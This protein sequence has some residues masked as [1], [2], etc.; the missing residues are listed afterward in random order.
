MSDGQSPAKEVTG[1]GGT[2]GNSGKKT[3]KMSDGQSPAKEVTGGGGTAG[4]SGKK[5]HKMSDGQSPAKE[6]TGG[7]GTAGNSGN[8]AAAKDVTQPPS[9][10]K[11]GRVAPVPLDKPI[12][13]IKLRVEP[14][15]EG[16]KG[17]KERHVVIVQR[18]SRTGEQHG[19]IRFT[20]IETHSPDADVPTE[21]W[22]GHYTKNGVQHK[23]HAAPSSH[24][25]TP[26]NHAK[27]LEVLDFVYNEFSPSGAKFYVRIV[28]DSTVQVVELLNDISELSSER[29]CQNFLEKNGNLVQVRWALTWQ[30]YREC[31]KKTMGQQQ[32]LPFKP[33]ARPAEPTFSA[34]NLK[35]FRK[36]IETVYFS[37]DPYDRLE[38]QVKLIAA[39]QMIELALDQAV[40]EI[41]HFIPKELHFDEAMKPD[42]LTAI[43]L[44]LA[45]IPE[46]C[47]SDSAED[48]TLRAI[49]RQLF[50]GYNP[51]NPDFKN[52]VMQLIDFHDGQISS[53][54]SKGG[55]SNTIYLSRWFCHFYNVKTTTHQDD[56]SLKL[57]NRKV[58]CLFRFLRLRE[59]I[60]T[61]DCQFLQDDKS[62]LIA[63]MNSTESDLLDLISSYDEDL[64]KAAENIYH[65]FS[66]QWQEL[67][68]D[69][70]IQRAT[71]EM[72]SLYIQVK[73]RL[74]LVNRQRGETG[75]FLERIE[76]DLQAALQKIQ[77]VENPEQM[78]IMN[79]KEILARAEMNFKRVIEFDSSQKSQSTGELRL[80][81]LQ[82][83]ADLDEL[84]LFYKDMQSSILSFD[85]TLQAR[86]Q[87]SDSSREAEELTSEEFT[88]E[89]STE[90]VK[91]SISKALNNIMELRESAF[92][93]PLE[94]DAEI[95][96]YIG[97]QIKTM[98]EKSLFL[99]PEITAL[100][101]KKITKEDSGKLPNSN[102]SELFIKLS[103]C[104]DTDSLLKMQQALSQELTSRSGKKNEVSPPSPSSEEHF[105]E[106]LKR[107]EE[108]IM[109]LGNELLLQLQPP[110]Q[111]R[112]CEGPTNEQQPP[113]LPSEQRQLNQLQWVAFVRERSNEERFLFVIQSLIRQEAMD[114]LFPD[115]KK[116]KNLSLRYKA[117]AHS[118][119]SFTEATKDRKYGHLEDP[120][121]ERLQ[122]HFDSLDSKHLA[123]QYVDERMLMA[124]SIDPRR[125]GICE[126]VKQ[127]DDSS[128]ATLQNAYDQQ[129]RILKKHAQDLGM[130]LSQ[131]HFA[132]YFDVPSI[133]SKPPD[134]SDVS[135]LKEDLEAA[136]SEFNLKNQAALPNGIFFP[137][138]IGL[139]TIREMW[140]ALEY[141]Y[142]LFPFQSKRR[143]PKY[144]EAPLYQEQLEGRCWWQREGYCGL[145]P[146]P[147]EFAT[148]ATVDQHPQFWVFDRDRS[149]GDF[150]MYALTANQLE[151]F[152]REPDRKFQYSTS[153]PAL[154]EYCWLSS[155]T[156]FEDWEK[157]EGAIM[158]A[159]CVRDV[160]GRNSYMYE[161]HFC[162]SKSKQQFI[163]R[164]E[165]EPLAKMFRCD[166][167][168]NVISKHEL[169]YP[170]N[171]LKES[172][173]RRGSAITAYQVDHL[174]PWV[175]GGLTVI[176]NLQALQHN[177]NVAKLNDHIPSGELCFGLPS[178]KLLDMYVYLHYVTHFRRH[179]SD[180][181]P[182]NP[183]PDVDFDKK[184]GIDSDDREFG[185]IDSQDISAAERELRRS[186]WVLKRLEQIL[187]YHCPTEEYHYGGL[188]LS[189][190]IAQN[191]V[192]SSMKLRCG[193]P[194]EKTQITML[195]INK[196]R[197]FYKTILYKIYPEIDSNSTQNANLQPGYQI[198]SYQSAVNSKFGMRAPNPKRAVTERGSAGQ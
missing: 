72:R 2:A 169:K 4:N 25:C 145:E 106:H 70:Q 174:F 40:P 130:P 120:V 65:D 156:I 167:C 83:L 96:D 94:S 171:K 28:I 76:S 137:H 176:Q 183:D 43:F 56:K 90:E 191:E 54:L 1:G 69:L 129:W 115:N 78:K 98:T 7:G 152:S 177:A 118:L 168:R 175:C 116:Y 150:A 85:A 86:A 107:N 39:M 110:R 32:L 105:F 18:G 26:E 184:I 68:H 60:S 139:P 198:P 74:R 141:A 89:T 38:L 158:P 109:E 46:A 140:E 127:A 77:F 88:I 155:P 111:S 67:Q 162:D 99:Q 102:L 20:S 17:A 119:S 172:S 117:Y 31:L 63:R 104:L 47:H 173:K 33:S 194:R 92:S 53:P 52:I 144:W 197:Q 189:L 58:G 93:S 113:F 66:K 122:K 154:V 193:L 15:D 36:Q 185:R 87:R 165:L 79:P 112:I 3:H 178:P 91:C 147:H 30:N 151:K 19:E 136:I 101:K 186:N 10:K 49:R 148:K 132:D 29:F 37:N 51:N 163:I 166:A 13:V 35:A 24:F 182:G 22:R 21:L 133:L 179:S 188:N 123:W 95:G 157:E 164:I 6:V 80:Q 71:D 97:E 126:F 16:V 124:T 114:V 42:C 170:P 59:S 45:R 146:F 82:H 50:H 23:W 57:L 103:T 81:I 73:D 195:T 9:L 61:E 34:E 192:L 11:V 180:F 135:K 14:V 121:I 149:R 48:T 138:S 196:G 159:N 187:C 125:I 161:A 181:P 55:P 143:D 108:E 8:A 12:Q 100:L 44:R 62:T 5:T 64:V 134:F 190:M 41:L 142:R 84:E 128:V 131:H 75:C 160:R 153:Q 27:L